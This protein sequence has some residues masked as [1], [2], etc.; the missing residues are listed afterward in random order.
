MLD[1]KQQA[2]FLQ[3]IEPSQREI[4]L[5]SEISLPEASFSIKTN[6][7]TFLNAIRPADD[8]CGPGGLWEILPAAGHAGRDADHQG[9]SLLEQVRPLNTYI[10]DIY[11]K[12]PV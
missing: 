2:S 11:S 10:S 8:D 5:N 4:S 3:P 6:N 9:E 7:L 1:A 12:V